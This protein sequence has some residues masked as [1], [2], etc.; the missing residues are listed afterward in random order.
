MFIVFW[1]LVV[2]C[3]C[4]FYVFL[5]VVYSDLGDGNILDKS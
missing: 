1:L 4:V 2:L 3:I 5:F